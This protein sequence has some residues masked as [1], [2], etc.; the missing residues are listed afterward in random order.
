MSETRRTIA[1]LHKLPELRREIRRVQKHMAD[2]TAMLARD[3]KDMRESDSI[4]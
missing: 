1:A 3:V 2:I 4:K